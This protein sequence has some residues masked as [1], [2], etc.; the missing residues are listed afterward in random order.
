MLIRLH[1]YHV[2]ERYIFTPVWNISWCSS[3]NERGNINFEVSE[4]CHFLS[5]TNNADVI[6][7]I[8][9]MLTQFLP[10]LLALKRMWI[11]SMD[12]SNQKW[13]LPR[14]Q[15]IN[16]P[17]QFPL[18]VDWRWQEDVK[19]DIKQSSG[20]N[21]PKSRRA[22]GGWVGTLVGRPRLHSESLHSSEILCSTVDTQ[23]ATLRKS[24]VDEIRVRHSQIR[25]SYKNNHSLFSLHL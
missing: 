1:S 21:R 16:L 10:Q 25:Q 4:F 11:P 7:H 12:G 2:G 5:I 3:L 9:N 8:W 15:R 6:W 13:T 20:V 24:N 19:A 23:A 17:F 14:L 22:V 18:V